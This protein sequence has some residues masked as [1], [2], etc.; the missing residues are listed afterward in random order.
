MYRFIR[1]LVKIFYYPL[2]RVKVIGDSSIKNGSL[3]VCNHISMRDP[4]LLVLALKNDQYIM[5]KK[6][7]FRTRIGKWFYS[8]AHVFPVDRGAGDVAAIRTCVNVLRR[9]DSLLLF[10]QGKRVKGVIPDVSDAKGG[11]GLIAAMTGA[12]IVPVSIYTRGHRIR[13]MKRVYIIIG[14]AITKEEYMSVTNGDRD[15]IARYAFSKVI[16][17]LKDAQRRYD[18]DDRES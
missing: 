10:P 2:C 9:G 4:V 3:I 17:Q 1:L 14:D 18:G 16:E 7:L 15:G 5:A 6:E 8:M 12:D 11:I 13:F